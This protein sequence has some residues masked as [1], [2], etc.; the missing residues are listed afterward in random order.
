VVKKP[1]ALDDHQRS[2]DGAIRALIQYVE[3]SGLRVEAA[4]DALNQAAARGELNEHLAWA[5]AHCHA[6][7]R[8]GQVLSKRTYYNWVSRVAE[9]GHAA[10]AKPE[11]NLALPAWGAAF[12]R[13]YRR[14]QKPT[15][16]EAAAAARA[17]LGAA[18][19]FSDDQVYRLIKKIE[20]HKPEILY[21][22]R[23]QGAG[24]VAMLPYI[25]RSTE[26]LWSNDVWT[27]DGHG[28]KA[29][30]AH[31]DHGRP[32]SPEITL[33]MDVA[34]NAAMGWSISYSENVIAVCDALRHSVSQHDLPLVYYS[35]NGSGQT[36]RQLDAPVG[37]ML[38]R[39]GIHHETGRPGNPQG[40]GMIERLWQTLTVPLARQLPTFFGNGADGDYLRRTSQQ[41]EKDLR[42][43]GTS[44]KLMSMADFCALFEKVVHWYNHEH[45][46]SAHKTTPMQ[47]YKA[48]LREQDMVKLN[49][50]ELDDLFRPTELRRAERGQVRL[51]NNIY[52]SRDLMDVDGQQVLVGY[53]IHDP[54][55]V[56]IRRRDGTFVCRAEWNANEVDYFPTSLVD[57]KRMERAAGKLKRAESRIYE[58]EAE[59]N[60]PQLIDQA[61]VN[62]LSGMMAIPPRA[63]LLVP[64]KAA[65]PVSKSLANMG[66]YSQLDH[67]ARNPDD[68]TPALRAYFKGQASKGR[69]T[70][71]NALDEFGLW[72]MLEQQDF[73]VAV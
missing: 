58:A 32:F 60:P 56:V 52:F 10:P 8:C 31:P 38:A 26:S 4:L 22:G 73:K 39:L 9:R 69:R 41:I 20:A 5:Y 29:K 44:N 12:L 48:R 59:L 68:W 17:E 72:G 21:R 3:A 55:H 15:A 16:R 35:D 33:I 50:A 46:H 62:T 18:A 53:D 64:E 37:G 42:A 51:W 63:E 40:R 25:R 2:V 27:G 7:V 28:F 6:K 14:P 13:H 43:S 11:Q 54:D 70:V 67:L 1:L 49:P 47:A 65:T 19:S 34:S 36:A 23:N 24:L 57:R 71:I 61:P 66:D 30:I 45:V